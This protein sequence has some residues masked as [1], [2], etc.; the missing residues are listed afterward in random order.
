MSLHVIE[1]RSN[2]G[3]SGTSF[4]YQKETGFVLLCN[5]I[6]LKESP[7]FYT[8]SQVKPK[9]II[10]HLHRFYLAV[11]QLHAITPSFDSFAAFCLT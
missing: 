1:R 2:G 7:H 6:D 10:T 11:R 9:L 5:M 3:S 8:P 4:E